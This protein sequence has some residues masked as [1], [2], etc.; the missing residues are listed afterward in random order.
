MLVAISQINK[1]GG[2]SVP[3]QDFDIV[4]ESLSYYAD[5]YRDED[6]GHPLST[7][8]YIMQDYEQYIEVQ[9]SI[10][11]HIPVAAVLNA[12]I[13]EED[14]L[15]YYSLLSS[16]NVKEPAYDEEAKTSQLSRVLSSIRGTTKSIIYFYNYVDVGDPTIKVNP[17]ISNCRIFSCLIYGPDSQL[18][19]VGISYVY[20][21]DDVNDSTLN[22]VMLNLLR[23]SLPMID[24]VEIEELL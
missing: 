1:N 6:S 13:Y 10:I 12:Q 18:E 22:N 20:V 19:P 21:G 5:M 24:H 2:G 16:S 15:L 4:R 14:I 11:P 9:E 3:A 7:E 23:Q 8:L 17:L